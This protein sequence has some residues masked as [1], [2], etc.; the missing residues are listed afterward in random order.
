MDK[1]FDTWNKEKKYLQTVDSDR[2]LFEERDIWWCSI[3][4]NLGSEEDGKNKF[5]ERP[6]LIA[7]KFN[8]RMAWVVPITSTNRM[9]RYY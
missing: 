1:D 9:H 8:S 7:K 4:V 6:V 5:F 3:G 2:F